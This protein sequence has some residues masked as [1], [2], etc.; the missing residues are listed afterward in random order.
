MSSN[1]PKFASFRPKPKAPEQPSEQ[2]S[3]EES[4]H[5]EEK[6]RR[7]APSKEKSRHGSSRDQP[8]DERRRSPPREKRQHTRGET[9]TK[10]FF[11]DRRGDLDIVKYGTLNRYDVPSYRRSGYGNVLGL[12]YQKIDREFS[13]DKKIYMVPLVRQRKKRMLT[14]RHAARENKRTLRLVKAA[15][16]HQTD[17]TQDF[18]ALSTSNK[19]KRDDDSSSDDAADVD[20]RGFDDKA[21]ADQVDD[22]D[23]YYESDVEM[24][25]INS[26]VTQKNSRLVRET[27]EE[28]GNLQAWLGLIE[29]QE[30]MMKLD[31]TVAELSPVD[32]QNLADVR[33]STYEEALRKIGNNEADR[34][35]L[36]NGLMREA[37][38]HWDHA[39]VATTWQDVLRKHPRSTK[40]WFGYIDFFQSTFATFKYETCRAVYLKAFETLRPAKNGHDTIPSEARLHL[41]VRLTAMIHDAGYQEL[42]LAIWQAYFELTVLAPQVDAADRLGRFEEFWESEAPRIGEPGAKGW[43]S[44]AVEEAVP[45]IGSI[46]LDPPDL[47]VAPLLAF[48]DRELECMDK[49]RYPGRSTDEV[50]EDDPFHTIFYTDLQDYIADF[51]EV[52]V[53]AQVDAYLCFCGLPSLPMIDADWLWRDDPVLQRGTTDATSTAESDDGKSPFE[54]ALSRYSQSPFANYRMT[55]DILIQ[56]S[57]LLVASR[58]GP[59]FV[60]NSLKLIVTHSTDNELIGEYLLAFESRHFPS[61]VAKTAKRLLK[62]RPTSIRL[63]NMYGLVEDHL[64]NSAKAEQVFAAALNIPSRTEDHLE[65]LDSYVWQALRAGNNNE[66]L[67]RLVNAT[68]TASSASSIRST[69][70]TLQSAQTTLQTALERAL[71]DHSLHHAVQLTTHLA[72]LTYLTPSPSPSNQLSPGLTIHTSLHSWLTSHNLSL[73]PWAELLAQSTARLLTHHTLSTAILP[74]STL[75]TALTPLLTL[76]P[77]NTLLL[78]AFAANEAR[79]AIDDRVHGHVQRVLTFG[80]EAEG[81][82]VWGFRLHHETL[83]GALAGSTAHSI[84]AVLRRATHPDARGAHCPAL[85]AAWVRFERAELRGCVDERAARARAKHRRGNNRHEA[86]GGSTGNKAQRE[87]ESEVESVSGGKFADAKVEQARNRARDV[88]YAAVKAVPW[89]KG[90]ILLGCG[91]AGAK[92]VFDDDEEV[93]RLWRVA[94]EKEMRLYNELEA[95]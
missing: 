13:T 41:F 35:E 62:A 9:S 1:V 39:K 20:Y 44:T 81:L 33:I 92:G 89:S 7:D 84:R 51:P 80:N 25:S 95:E 8:R 54:A 64:G 70:T 37:Q 17:A 67:E 43:K 14:D 87:N 90:I 28:P 56:Q 38:R 66:A 6:R 65:L 10:P 45:P 73:S 30:S 47:S 36:Y 55:K 3:L 88:V 32:R 91:E 22:P 59:D 5:R 61:E 34:V 21:A 57:F 42:A 49:L 23:T 63:Y 69:Q 2:P 53:D 46:S 40:L 48:H 74:P 85:W 86:S 19:R 11:S 78:S 4:R 94:E 72:L 60:R 79:A 75:R 77:H 68:N 16:S 31:R 26:Q 71:L 82:S 58:L 83:R 93:R 15:E 24:A 76:F 29:H 12:P 27:R 52:P 50:G 18:I